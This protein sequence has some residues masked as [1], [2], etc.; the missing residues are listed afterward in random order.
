[1]GHAR[2]VPFLPIE[3]IS[4]AFPSRNYV[5]I[6]IIRRI[7][8]DYFGYSI[9]FIMNIT[10]VD[11]KIIVRGRHQH[12]VDEYMKKVANS[13]FT[14]E[15]QSEVSDYWAAFVSKTFPEAS[16]KLASIPR[17]EWVSF[18]KT[19]NIKQLEEN[20][21]KFSNKY[22]VIIDSSIHL[23]KL[24]ALSL[25][26]F[27]SL[28]SDILGPALDD[29]YGKTL[30]NP[31][32]FRKLAEFWEKE[33]MKDMDTLGVLRPSVLTRVSEYIPEIIECTSQIMANG[34]VIFISPSCIILIKW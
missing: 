22:K 30:N 20:D 29:L 14:P 3:E 19:L 11:D 6:D 21:P 27:S 33:F 16:D 18:L 9:Q 34:Y 24:D 10:D 12:L 25:P 13:G 28:F 8:S 1:M 15:I 4:N 23:Q 32:I 31:S 5:T 17:S 7:L 2:F 26:E